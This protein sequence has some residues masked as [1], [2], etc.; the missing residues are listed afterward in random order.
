M[1]TRRSN[2]LNFLLIIG[3]LTVFLSILS[4]PE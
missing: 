4:V 2:M 1:A 3:L